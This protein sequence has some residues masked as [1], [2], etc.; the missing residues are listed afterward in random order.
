MKNIVT[1]FSH[2]SVFLKLDTWKILIQIK[3]LTEA[4]VRRCSVKNVFLEISQK[5]QENTRARVYNFIKK[6]TLAQMFSYK[7]CEISKNIFFH[8]T[9]LAAASK[10]TQAMSSL[11]STHFLITLIISFIYFETRLLNIFEACLCLITKIYML[12]DILF[13]L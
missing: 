10:L 1:S 6:E 11:N 8:R 3:K 12:K 4:V 2:N 7:F 9:P 5:S 13:C